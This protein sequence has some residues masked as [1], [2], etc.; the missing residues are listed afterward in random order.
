MIFN[1]AKELGQLSKLKVR[2]GVG[3]GDGGGKASWGRGPRRATC[4]RDRN[5][6][7]TDLSTIYL[8]RCVGKDVQSSASDTT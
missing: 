5:P 2:S 4:S 1:A 3:A 8:F 7:L 6:A